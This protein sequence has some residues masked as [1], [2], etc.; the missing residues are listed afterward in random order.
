MTESPSPYAPYLPQNFNAPT[1]RY[2]A[3]LQQLQQDRSA[4]AGDGL[5]FREPLEEALQF[6][7]ELK[8]TAMES[9]NRYQPS[10]LTTELLQRR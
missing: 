10:Q 3:L 2:L 9:L 1:S 5:S 4:G 7:P 6:A 8:G